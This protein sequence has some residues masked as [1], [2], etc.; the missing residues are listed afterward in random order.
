MHS[1]LKDILTEKQREVSRLKNEGMSAN[2]HYDSFLIRNFEGAISVPGR[3]GL[4]AEIKF[5]S[6][7]AGIIR[8]KGDPL[9]IG[10]IYEEAGAAAIS[11]ITDK[12]FFGGDINDLARLKGAISLP[13]LRKDFIIDTVQVMESFLYGADAVLLIARILSR[14]Q[15]RELL[16]ACREFGLAPLTEVHDRRDLEKAVECGAEILGIN[17]RDLDT[18]RVDIKITLDLAPLV[19]E[20]CAVVSESGIVNGK[21]IRSLSGYGVRAVLV[22]SSLMKSD[23]MAAKT[24]ELVDEGQDQAW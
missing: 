1:R 6:P 3:I 14:R 9:P 11:L 20:G 22:G 2:R 7:S 12:L 8:E 4:I 10:Q 15:L 13:V 24:K 19:P 18:F 21:D 17:N 5:A 23:D 16:A